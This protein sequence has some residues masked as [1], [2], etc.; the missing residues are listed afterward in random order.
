MRHGWRHTRGER[1]LFKSGGA[2]V[3]PGLRGRWGGA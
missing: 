2:R 3:K 1:W